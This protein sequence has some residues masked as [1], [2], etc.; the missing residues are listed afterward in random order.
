MVAEVIGL[1]GKVVD[2]EGVLHGGPAEE[3]R[4]IADQIEAGDWGAVSSY[5][6]VIMGDTVEVFGSDVDNSGVS[7]ALL[8]QAGVL[9]VISAVERHGRG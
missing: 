5:A 3:L 4:R 7:V 8:L 2:I 6:V 9:R 1:D